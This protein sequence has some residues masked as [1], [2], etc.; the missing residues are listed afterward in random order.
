[1]TNA[2][3]I[4]RVLLRSFRSPVLTT[5]LA[6]MSA[7]SL[8]APADAQSAPVSLAVVN[9]RIW[10]GNPKRPWAEAIAVRGDRIAA[11]GSSAEIRKIT[12]AGAKVVDAHGQMLVPGFNDAHVHIISAGRGLSSV[13]LRDASTPAEFI[14]RIKAYAKTIPKGAWITDGDWDHTLWGGELPT[15]QWIDSVT[16]D[17]P[18]WVA[19]LDGHMSLANSAALAAAHVT[20]ATPDVEGGLIV[21]DASGEPTGLLKDNAQGLVDDSM[22]NPPPE[23][24]DRAFDA[25]MHFLAERGVTSAQNMG[26][27]WDDLAI[28]ERAHKA[29][30]MI[31]RMYAVVPL[32]TW[33]QLRDTVAARGHGD[34]WVRIGGLKGFV[35]GSLG[36]HTAAMLRPFDDSPKDSGLFVTPP[37][38][39]YAR[40][41]GADK[42]G[43][44]V[45]VHAIG[46]RAIRVQLD[47]YARVEKENGPKD[48]RFRIEHAQH[49]APSDI[50]RFG[51]LHVIASMQPYHEMDDGRWAEAIIGHERSKTTYAFKSVLDAG[52]RLAFGSDWSVAP[53]T[54]IEGIYGAVTRETLDGKHPGGWIPEQKITVEDALRAYTSGSAY[55]SFEENIKGTLE[56]NKLADFVLIDRD[57]TRI[58]PEQI[59]DA[60]IVMTFVGGRVVYQRE[61]TATK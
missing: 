17:N 3:R 28:F 1:M 49:I 16:P 22:P 27:S 8:A 40:T 12:G 41:L 6:M 36:S 60:H 55:A 7:F 34:E 47:N 42:A 23:V 53:P 50:P 25:A 56:P 18:V 48:R 19:R 33:E 37:E 26:A 46:D 32:A 20:K 45:M 21:R 43:L 52:A 51:T 35:D 5:V 39:L 44:Q 15:R 10:T 14:A 11:V 54:P 29:G 38:S 9:A 57:L 58:P 4:T 13:K 61:E 30:R 2:S 59:R 24:A 31:T